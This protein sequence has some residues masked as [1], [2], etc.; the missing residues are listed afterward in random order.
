MSQ[1]ASSEAREAYV[2]DMR[3]E[4]TILKACK[5]PNVVAFLVSW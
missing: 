3:R 2:S 5:D 4:V 1:A